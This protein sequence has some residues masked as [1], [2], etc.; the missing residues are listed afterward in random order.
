MHKLFEKDQ[1][2]GVDCK[3]MS[4][5]YYATD[6]R[7]G[8][9][10]IMNPRYDGKLKQK[11]PLYGFKAF[12]EEIVVEPTP[13]E[14]LRTHNLNGI[15]FHSGTY[16]LY[17]FEKNDYFGHKDWYIG[18]FK[19]VDFSKTGELIS[20]FELNQLY[21]KVGDDDPMF[22]RDIVTVINNLGRTHGR[23]EYNE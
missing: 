20:L 1:C 6:I 8:E 21:E 17:G 14:R 16:S 5:R 4:Q 23:N 15:T 9:I 11:H 7:V 18:D 12:V 19:G 22:Q 2:K 13:I 3:I 10:V